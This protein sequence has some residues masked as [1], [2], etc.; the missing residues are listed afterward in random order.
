M[1]VI[2]VNFTLRKTIFVILIFV[3]TSAIIIYIFSQL[4]FNAILD[5]LK[6]ANILLLFPT[7]LLIIVSFSL[8]TGRWNLLL[9]SYKLPPSIKLFPILCSGI[10]INT[11]IPLRVGEFVRRYWL[12]QDRNTSFSKSLTSVIIERFVDS[13]ALVLITAFSIIFIFSDLQS[14]IQ[15]WLFSVGIIALFIAFFVLIRKPWFVNFCIKILQTIFKPAKQIQKKAVEGMSELTKD[16]EDL[17]TDKRN[18]PL[19]LLIAFPIWILEASKVYILSIAVGYPLPFGVALFIGATSYLLG[20]SIVNPAGLSQLLFMIGLFAFLFPSAL[21][22]CS[23][24]AILDWFVSF[25]WLLLS[26][27]PSSLYYSLK[28]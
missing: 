9:S 21:V 13:V 18:T 4:G 6:Q 20:A 7:F 17:I 3:V 5:A 12:S 15:S 26:G 1:R 27:A 14:V 24:I 22:I 28:I 10:F 25:S 2:S 11:I 8:R 16:I 23:V 19:A